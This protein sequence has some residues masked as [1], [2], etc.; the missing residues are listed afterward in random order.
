MWVIKLND[1]PITLWE[2]RELEKAH[3]NLD[4]REYDQ[5]LS[6]RTRTAAINLYLHYA[7]FT[8]KERAAGL[9]CTTVCV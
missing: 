7:G 6:A 2:L 9:H 4:S 3:W 1:K 5:F 8:W